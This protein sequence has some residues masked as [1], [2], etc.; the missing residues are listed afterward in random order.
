MHFCLPLKL[1]CGC[2]MYSL[3]CIMSSVCLCCVCDGVQYNADVS[4]YLSVGGCAW[5]LIIQT[6]LKLTPW[7]ECPC[8]CLC[9]LIFWLNAHLRYWCKVDTQECNPGTHPHSACHW[10]A[11]IWFNPLRSMTN[12]D[13]YPVTVCHDSILGWAM[14]RHVVRRTCKI[15]YKHEDRSHDNYVCAI[16][17]CLRWSARHWRWCW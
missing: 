9:L 15:P 3:S 8:S 10:L 1:H 4:P 7:F 13:L 2:Y 16:D 14:E 11:M 12:L 17:K 6:G 5:R